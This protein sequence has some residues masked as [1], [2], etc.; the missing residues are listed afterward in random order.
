MGFQ[1]QVNKKLALGKVGEFYDDSPR[2]VNPVQVVGTTSAKAKATLTTTGNF[3]ASDTVTI[4]VQTYKFVASL[5][6][7]PSP[8]PYEV[9][10]GASASAS[11]INLEKAINGTGTA[12]TEYSVGTEKNALATA[13]ASTSTLVVT[14]KADGVEGN[15]VAVAE[16]SSS[17]TFGT[18]E[19]L[20]DGS[21]EVKAKIGLA[22][23]LVEEGKARVGGTGAFMGIAVNPEDYAI[24]NNF[25][26]TMEIPSGVAGQLCTFGHILVKVT[27]S[28]TIGQTAFYNN[29]DGT[30]KGGTSGAS[31]AGYTEIKNSKFINFNAGANE[32]AVLELG[33]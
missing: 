2:R 32:I 24:Y 6:S 3:S 14:A 30:I 5:T 27:D 20:A 18:D 26:P 1:K 15:S 17:A 10:L 22:F 9:V 23:T 31:V 11:L 28:I 29:T 8:V 19:T 16:T 12:G 13:S 25:N 4:G 33:Q 7:S 21:D